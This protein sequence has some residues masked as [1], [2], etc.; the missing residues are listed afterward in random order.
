MNRTYTIIRCGKL[1]DGITPEWKEGFSI[2]VENDRIAEVGREIPEPEGARIVDLTDAQVTP[3][4]IDAHMHMDYIDWHTV[5]EEV[6]TTSEEAKTLAA[7]RTAKKCLERGFTTVRH[8]GGITSKGYGILDV[9]RAIERGY[10]EGARIVAAP[11]FLCSAGS[12]GDLSQGFA[13]NPELSAV[14]QSHRTTLGSGKDFFVNAV[15]EQVKY[16]S[17][18][19]KIMATGGFFTPNDTPIQ[20]QL[21]DEELEAIIT[22]AHE[23]GRTVTAHVYTNELMQKLIRFG[24]DGMEHGALMNE[25]TAAMF[26]EKNLYLVPTFCPYEEAVHYD[27]EAIKLKQPEFRRKLELYK[28]VLQAGRQVICKSKI[29]LGYGTD[30]VANHQNYESGYEYEAWMNSGMDPFR[31]LMAATSVNAGILGLGDQIGTIQKGKV[32][33]I[34]AW[35]RD[36]MKDPKALLDCAFVM[37]EGKEYR[38]ESCLQG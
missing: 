34:A 22:T 20:Q 26:E 33:D 36:L 10:L 27:P 5:R 13:G 18:F 21:N 29:R 32:A 4:M 23:L 31:T 15:R 35:K 2:L 11:L 7:A 28:D 37:K 12:H 38:T 25:E 24:I 17:D 30:F 8:T 14:L 1:F 19:L 9:K 3:G 6:Y 16:G